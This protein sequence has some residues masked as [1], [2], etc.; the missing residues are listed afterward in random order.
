LIV[1]VLSV[2]TVIFARFVSSN[3]SPSIEGL[4]NVN[5]LLKTFN[6]LRKSSLEVKELKE[7]KYVYY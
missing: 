5:K 1:S 7:A 4:V 2:G 6:L 3:F